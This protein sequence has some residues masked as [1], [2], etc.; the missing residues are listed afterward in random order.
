[1]EPQEPS[2]Q[3]S[4]NIQQS[5]GNQ[6]TETHADMNTAPR[7]MPRTASN[8]PLLALL[9]LAGIALSF[10]FRALRSEI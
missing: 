6:D 4:F 8:L 10:L 3:E 9:G 5:P 7:S 1:M 2:T